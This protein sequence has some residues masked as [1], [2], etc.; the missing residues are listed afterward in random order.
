MRQAMVTLVKIVEVTAESVAESGTVEELR[1]NL[2]E[3][4]PEVREFNDTVAVKKTV[5]VSLQSHQ[6][7][8]FQVA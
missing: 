8:Q 6:L 2:L 3:I 4:I 5:P 1:E 7:L